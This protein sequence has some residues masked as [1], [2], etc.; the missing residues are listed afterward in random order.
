VGGYINKFASA[1]A[2]LNV[3]TEFDTLIRLQRNRIS[4]FAEGETNLTAPVFHSR[5]RQAEP[6]SSR[7]LGLPP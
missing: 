5:V 1:E 3:L 2:S 7:L 4:K 6:V